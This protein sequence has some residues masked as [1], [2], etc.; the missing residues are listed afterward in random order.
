[1]VLRAVDAVEQAASARFGAVSPLDEEIARPDQVMKDRTHGMRILVG[2]EL[3]EQV[4][5]GLAR[6][7]GNGVSSAPTD[8]HSQLC[9]AGETVLLRNGVLHLNQDDL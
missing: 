1:M 7:K 6:I 2:R 5:F 4:H 9:P 3:Y 8:L